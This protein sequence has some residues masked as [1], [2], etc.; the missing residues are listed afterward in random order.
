MVGALA[1]LVSVVLRI[2]GNRRSTPATG[3]WRE[4]EGPDFR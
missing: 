3:A 1:I 2:R 4:L